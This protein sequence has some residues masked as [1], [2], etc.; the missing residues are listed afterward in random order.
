MQLKSLQVRASL[1]K[2]CNWGY[3]GR[4]CQKFERLVW[5]GN[6]LGNNYVMSELFLEEGEVF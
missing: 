3:G 4:S 6:M 1:R 5:A 2:D